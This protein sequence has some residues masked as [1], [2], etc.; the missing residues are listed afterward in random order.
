MLPNSG[1]S[2]VSDWK[3]L[4]STALLQQDKSTTPLL[5]AEAQRAIIERARE[6]FKSPTENLKEERE[7][8]VALSTLNVLKSCLVP[9]RKPTRVAERDTTYS[10]AG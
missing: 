8:D 7:L 10:L 2:G 9:Y 6:L 5:I 3:K 1:L 4:Y